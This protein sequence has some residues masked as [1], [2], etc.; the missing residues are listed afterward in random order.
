MMRYGCAG[1]PAK[2][3]QEILVGGASIPTSRGYNFGRGSMQYT[4][5][6]GHNHQRIILGLSL[7]LVDVLLWDAGQF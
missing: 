5:R 7:T 1:R 3:G 6:Y 4:C 2:G